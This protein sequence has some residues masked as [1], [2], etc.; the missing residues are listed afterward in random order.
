MGKKIL[1]L[2]PKDTKEELNSI[3]SG[4]VPSER[5]YGFLEIQELGYEATVA[6]FHKSRA[7]RSI[8]LMLRQRGIILPTFRSILQLKGQ[9]V[10]VIKDN[11]QLI[12]PLIAKILGKKV[13]FFDSLFLLPRNFLKKA[14]FKFILKLSYKV[15]SFSKYQS[16]LW[17]D[18]YPQQKN[19]FVSTPYSMDTSFYKPVEKILDSKRL[20]ILAVGRDP[21]RSFEV[22]NGLA[23]DSE[24]QIHLVTLPYLLNKVQKSSS[25][26]LYSYISYNELFELYGK[27]DLSIVALKQGLQYPSGIRAVFE[28]VLLGVPVVCDKNEILL[29]YLDDD[30]VFYCDT[31]NIVELLATLNMAY[32]NKKLCEEKIRNSRLKI[33]MLDIKGVVRDFANEIK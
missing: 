29:E 6:D 27:C 17:A 2:F 9:D 22:L 15:V 31:S 24:V 28:S 25:I 32:S 20:N 4:V 30:D 1:Y 23:Q 13:I 3:A 14:F 16:S 18:L 19:K 11:L 5:L 12:V 10:V 33:R 7:A 21:G 26:K 8:A